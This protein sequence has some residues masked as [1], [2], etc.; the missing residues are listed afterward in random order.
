MHQVWPAPEWM[1]CMGSENGG[2]RVRNWGFTTVQAKSQLATWS[3]RGS[4]QLKPTANTLLVWQCWLPQGSTLA[5]LCCS[6]AGSSS[7]LWSGW[8]ELT[9]AALLPYPTYPHWREH[10]LEESQ[11]NDSVSK[12]KAFP[13]HTSCHHFLH[14]PT[15]HECF[16]RHS[17]AVAVI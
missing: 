11:P 17:E 4:F 9:C 8:H 15:Y 14:F 13:A 16:G 1:K 7:W 10:T 2:G 6:H 3:Y 12:L 5:S